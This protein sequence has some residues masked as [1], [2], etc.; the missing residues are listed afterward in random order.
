MMEDFPFFCGWSWDCSLF[1][2]KEFKGA[3]SVILWWISLSCE[4]PSTARC[5]AVDTFPFWIPFN[6]TLHV[7]KG[8]QLISLSVSFCALGVELYTQDLFLRRRL[9]QY[10]FS[11]WLD[12]DWHQFRR[13]FVHA[14]FYGAGRKTT[15]VYSQ[16][17][18]WAL[19]LLRLKLQGTWK[20]APSRGGYEFVFV[21]FSFVYALLDS[22]SYVLQMW[23]RKRQNIPQNGQWMLETSCKEGLQSEGVQYS[24][25]RRRYNR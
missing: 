13:A 24:N 2:K 20:Q 6:G 3:A 17:L 14:L 1:F 8:F 7:F 4:T 15:Y 23:K 21:W 5:P 22:V 12:R 18:S 25:K 10:I 11:R 19:V 16:R 9:L